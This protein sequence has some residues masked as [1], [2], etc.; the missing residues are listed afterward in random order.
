LED[1]SFASEEDEDD[2]YLEDKE[3]KSL[4]ELKVRALSLADKIVMK[5][6]L[7]RSKHQQGKLQ[8]YYVG[9][10]CLNSKQ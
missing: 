9:K 6:D 1:E 2:E 5:K 4:E 8:N 3:P 7:I 10:N